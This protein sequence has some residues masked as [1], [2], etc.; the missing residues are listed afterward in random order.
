MSACAPSARSIARDPPRPP[1]PSPMSPASPRDRTQEL[2]GRD[3]QAAGPRGA[4]FH[5]RPVP[6]GYDVHAQLH[7]SCPTQ[8]STVR[9]TSCITRF[10]P[11]ARRKGDTPDSS[12]PLAMKAHHDLT[13]ALASGAVQKNKIKKH[14]DRGSSAGTVP[15]RLLQTSCTRQWRRQA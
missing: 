11:P 13:V 6:R 9:T 14:D 1:S 4:M 15:T 5:A 10:G 3:T 12:R 2:A 8:R 7:A